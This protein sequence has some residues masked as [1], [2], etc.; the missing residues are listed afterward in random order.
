MLLPGGY[1]ATDPGIMINIYYPIPTSY[2]YPGP[3][4]WKG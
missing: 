4:V 3:A 2:K 1:K